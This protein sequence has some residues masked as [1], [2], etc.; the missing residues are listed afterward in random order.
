MVILHLS[1]DVLESELNQD[2]IIYFALSAICVYSAFPSHIYI[3]I[4][5][6]WA[7]LL[8]IADFS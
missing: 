8:F 4:Y 1:S 7:I 6:F 2:G 3:Y 5:I